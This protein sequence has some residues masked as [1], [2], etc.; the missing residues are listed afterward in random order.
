MHRDSQVPEERIARARAILHEVDVDALIFF[1]MKNIRY[2]TG[3]TGSDGVLILGAKENILVVDG[4]YTNQA[5]KEVVG[6]RVVE[7]RDKIEGLAALVTEAGFGTVGIESQ[8]VTVNLYLALKEKLGGVALNPVADKLSSI[9]CIKDEKEIDFIRKAAEI[10]NKALA[11]ILDL[12]KPGT[13]ERDIAVEL[14]YRMRRCGAEEM[15]FP[16]IV[17]SGPNAAQPHAQP[18]LRAIEDGDL[19]IIDCGAAYSGYHSDETCTFAAGGKSRKQE[20]VYSLVKDAHDRAI[21][22]VRAGVPCRD[23]D[24]I[25]RECIE[26]GKLGSYFTHGTGHGVGLDVH[27]APRVAMNSDAVLE[28]GMV[29]TIEPGVYIPDLWGIRIEDMILVKDGG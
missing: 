3:F 15:S 20:E 2:L 1:D 22:A 14:D 26:D 13:K 10:S 8:S 11:A 29:I 24:R 19:V 17:A 9:R 6:A 18:G 5:R 28:A 23:I 12:I 25:A 4:R 27:E 21:A 7:C 16:T